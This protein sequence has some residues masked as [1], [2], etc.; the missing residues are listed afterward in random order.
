[1]QNLFRISPLL[2]LSWSGGL[3]CGDMRVSL[4]D[5]TSLHGQISYVFLIH[6]EVYS[7]TQSI[8]SP[9]PL[10]S[11]FS[12]IFMDGKL[13]GISCRLRVVCDRAFACVRE[14]IWRGAVCTHPPSVR[15]QCRRRVAFDSSGL[16]SP[17]VG[18]LSISVCFLWASWF[19]QNWNSRYHNFELP[20]MWTPF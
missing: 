8:P 6:P 15:E 18:D 13:S 14:E 9:S 12:F 3:S 17:S 10:G 20:V 5:L 1:M 7:E 4:S 2:F 11:P 16:A 19:L